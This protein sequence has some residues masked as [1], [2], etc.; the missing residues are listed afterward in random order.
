M[1]TLTKQELI[2]YLR[3]NLK[4]HSL[5]VVEY[6]DDRI[7][8]S[9]KEVWIDTDV[10]NAIGKFE[11]A[12]SDVMEIKVPDKGRLADM[13][14]ALHANGYSVQTAIVW[15]EPPETGVDYFI[16]RAEESSRN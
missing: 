13:I 8:V 7:S 1:K 3:A 16:V 4:S 12:Y 2:D 9:S 10:I 6:L 11:S 5:S 15:K 14:D